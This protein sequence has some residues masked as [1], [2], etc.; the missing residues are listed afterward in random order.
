MI[1]RIK[2]LAFNKTNETIPYI[3]SHLEKGRF[4]PVIDREYQ[5]KD[6]SKAY[7]YVINGKKTGSV[8]INV[9]KNV[10]TTKYEPN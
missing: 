7:E 8:L 1:S 4:K 10:G 6:I 2:L 9:K 3:I 5:L